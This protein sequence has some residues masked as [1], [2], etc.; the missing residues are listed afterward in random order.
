MT[1]SV[2]VRRAPRIKRKPSLI[3]GE[4]TIQNGTLIVSTKNN[5]PIVLDRGSYRGPPSDGDAMACTSLIKALKLTGTTRSN[6][7][8]ASLATTKPIS[9]LVSGSGTSRE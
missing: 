6:L 2:P 4:F 7:E 1:A 3:A 5:M 9:S 8:P